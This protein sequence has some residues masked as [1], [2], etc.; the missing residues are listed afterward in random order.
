MSQNPATEVLD[1]LSINRVENL[2][3]DVHL[4][5]NWWQNELYPVLTVDSL[6]LFHLFKSKKLEKS[7][8]LSASSPKLGTN[9]L[10]SKKPQK[11][12][13]SRKNRQLT[14]WN[15]HLC[16]YKNGCLVCAL[17]IYFSTQQVTSTLNNLFTTA[18]VKRV[19]E[20][21]EFSRLVTLFLYICAFLDRAKTYEGQPVLTEI[22]TI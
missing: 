12:F 8:V 1:K 2:L 3:P 14:V 6:S 16:A 5:T 17:Q 4:T 19:L 10:F 7:T 9:P 22:N 18:G 11:V 20:R 13:S 21:K 15:N